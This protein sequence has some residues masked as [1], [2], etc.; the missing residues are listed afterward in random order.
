MTFGS[1]AAFY[2]VVNGKIEED[3]GRTL[4]RRP[5]IRGVERFQVKA[6]LDFNLRHWRTNRG[7]AGRSSRLT[8][9]D[10]VASLLGLCPIFQT[11]R[12]QRSGI[13]KTSSDG[14]AIA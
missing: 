6:T 13:G 8:L 10:A 12:R 4:S 1:I 7:C 2:R 5:T 11:I 14:S 9:G 3:W